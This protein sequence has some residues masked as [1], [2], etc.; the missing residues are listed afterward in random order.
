MSIIRVLD[1]VTINKIAAGEVVESSASVVKELVENSLDAEA[2]EVIV[3]VQAGGRVLVRVSDDGIGMGVEDALLSLERHATS[4]LKSIEELSS[5]TSMGFRG[6]A[7]PSIASISKFSIL[8]SEGG[9]GVLVRVEGG[10]RIGCDPAVRPRGTTVE[11]KELFYNMPA[12][13][14][15]L[16]S[17]SADEN[18]I[19]KVFVN[20][21]LARPD[22]KFQLIVNQKSMF[23]LQPSEA[24]G[25][26]EGALG[27]SYFRELLPLN[28]SEGHYHLGGYIGKPSAVRPNRAGQYLFLNGRPVSSPYLSWALKEAY[29]THLPSGRFP[30]ATLW[31]TL[32]PEEVDV[33]VHPQKR[34]VR[35]RYEA[36]IK[37]LL[38]QA[39]HDALARD[40][41]PHP[42]SWVMESL[43][44]L[45]WEYV[46]AERAPEPIEAPLPLPAEKPRPPV[47][48][49]TMK[50]YILAETPGK[51]GLSLID[52]KRAHARVL[53]ERLSKGGKIEK[54]ALLIPLTLEFPPD[55]AAQLK[56]QL[57]DLGQLG[58]EIREFGPHTFAVDAY[59][60]LYSANS[61]KKVLSDSFR[62]DQW[63][64]RA[65]SLSI[66]SDKCLSKEEA[67]H[68][69]ADLFSCEHPWE[70]PL[71]KPTI[72]HLDPEHLTKS[73]L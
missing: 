59:P 67:C 29:S 1:E 23:L 13:K 10:K 61:I 69:V 28:R 65:T 73:F 38:F 58:F 57:H 9:E 27:S 2:K 53:Y 40:R 20:E 30:I 54:T 18:E 21:A 8:T 14:K 48:L 41:T 52:Q 66:S 39:V 7:I 46:P 31:L 55:E 37:R 34:E 68:L 51:E 35:L 3:E 72:A 24:S 5:I 62:D 4:K 56:E 42:A 45:P 6:E 16:K 60:A 43:S 26:I 36:E 17:P 19:V 50:G 15:F 70:S 47:V 71:G 63:A 64:K 12:R 32:P 11:V 22:V 44:P 49:A 33:N 25:R